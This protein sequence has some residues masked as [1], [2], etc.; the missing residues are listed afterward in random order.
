MLDKIQR[1][2]RLELMEAKVIYFD[3]AGN[4]NTEAALRAA[5]QRA[6]ELGIKTVVVASSSGNTGVKT[7][8]IFK[9]FKVIV[10]SHVTGFRGVNT[11][12]FTDANRK[13]IESQGGKVITMTHAFG[14]VSKAMKYKFDMIDIGDIIA[15]ALYIFGQGLKVCCEVTLMAADAGVIKV[16]EDVVAIGGTGKSGGADTAAVITAVNTQFFFDMVV[17]EII[18]KP[19]SYAIPDR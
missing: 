12:E 7:I 4:Q 3:K 15:N 2:R 16:N 1:N 14:G 9:G 6:D 11:Q 17:K 18:C 5:K 13:L 19:L 10:V 8:D